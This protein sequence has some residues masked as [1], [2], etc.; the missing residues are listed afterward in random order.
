MDKDIDKNPTMY[1]YCHNI[2]LSFADA[3]ANMQSLLK[4]IYVSN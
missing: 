3:V 1:G 2:V 4:E